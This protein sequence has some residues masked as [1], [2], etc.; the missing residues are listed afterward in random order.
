MENWNEQLLEVIKRGREQ[1]ELN[2][3]NELAVKHEMAAKEKER[4]RL[5]NNKSKAAAV[6]VTPCQMMVANNPNRNKSKE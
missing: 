3:R 1:R 4:E 6:V 2:H 5:N